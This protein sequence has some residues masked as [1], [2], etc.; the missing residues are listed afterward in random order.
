MDGRIS[1][2]SKHFCRQ[3]PQTAI[4]KLLLRL[5]EL[6]EMEKNEAIE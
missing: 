5:Y 4:D 3:D 2:S 6:A 1:S